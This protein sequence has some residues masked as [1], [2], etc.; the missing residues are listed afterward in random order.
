[1]FQ[2]DGHLDNEQIQGADTSTPINQFHTDYTTSS[3]GVGINDM[4]AYQQSYFEKDKTRSVEFRD[5]QLRILGEAIKENEN[6]IIDAI[7]KDLGKPSFE[8]I[9]SEVGFVYNDIRYARKHLA[10][11]M[12][13]QKAKGNLLTAPSRSMI[14]KEPLG[15]VL[16]IGPW[17]YPFQLIISPLIGAI[18]AGNCVVLKPSELAP[19][20]S[21]VVTELIN[22]SFPEEYIAVFEGGS[23]VSQSLLQHPWDHIFFTGSTRVGKI[24]AQAAAQSLSPTTLELGG[25]SPCIVH[26]DANL[27][28]AAKRITWGKFTNCGQTC[29]APDYLLVH[30]EV[31]NKLTHLICQQIDKF[32]GSDPQKSH[33]YGRIITR[34]HCERLSNL[35]DEGR[36]VKGGITKLEERYIS[37]TIID[38]INYSS[39][40]MQEEIFG[41][42]LPMLTY[43][44]L[45]QVITKIRRLPKPLALYFFSN[46]KAT[47]D[48]IM[49]NLSFGSGCINDTIMQL[50]NHEL[51][52]G[53]VGDS[54]QGAYHGKHSFDR[55]SHAKGILCQ[56]SLIDVPIRYP[57]YRK[58]K[59][60]ILRFIMK[61]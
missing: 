4:I 44:D 15:K 61:P 26:K 46:D 52:F 24:I 60:Q 20:T 47:Q 56:S 42:L 31:K 25:K 37:P 12:K 16:I 14:V 39:K 59:E 40:I 10:K 19:H 54:G 3:R 18:A 36:I 11:W 17:N 5:R 23:E 33:S 27:K 57:Q 34:S 8:T 30:K 38:G 50:V 2:N 1:M 35:L 53:G 29:V 45:S 51:P 22:E 48:M 13:P 43:D 21:K 58:W 28:L 49:L 32:Y 6:R 7:G 55:F 41:P 9:S